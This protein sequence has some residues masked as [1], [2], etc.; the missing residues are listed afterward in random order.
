[1]AKL[2]H[3]DIVSLDGYV[4]D[5][6]VKIGWNEPFE[7]LHRFL[8]DLDR[9]I[10]THLYGRR[11]YEIMSYW[12][13]AHEKPD[14]PDFILDYSQIWRSADKIVYSSTLEKPSSA[15]TR[16]ER[17]FDPE[18]VR[19]LKESATRDLAI[20][21]A[22]L[23][24]Q[25]HRAGLVDEICLVICPVLVGG[26]TRALPDGVRRN[27]TL[28]EQRTFSKGTMFVRYRVDG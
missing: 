5:E 16:I 13:T 18:A 28:I 24:A 6:N 25:A 1:M 14:L 7:E 11:L 19:A 12:E 23:A 15:R 21:G 17:T 8:N 2:I 4:N 20:G 22:N 9:P 10:G 3:T 26:G 27:L